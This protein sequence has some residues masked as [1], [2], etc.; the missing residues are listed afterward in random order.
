MS[1][2]VR[3]AIY[4]SSSTLLKQPTEAVQ[5]ISSYTPVARPSLCVEVGKVRPR[6][7]FM[8]KSFEVYIM[9]E[10]T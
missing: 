9:E 10:Q 4:T 6:L 7:P 5:S 3:G 2:V 1:A 8:N